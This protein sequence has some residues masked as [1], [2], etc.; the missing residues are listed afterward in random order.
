MRIAVENPKPNRMDG[1][2]PFFYLLVV[3]LAVAFGAY[4]FYALRML[5]EKETSVKMQMTF[6]LMLIAFPAITPAIIYLLYLDFF[7]RR[8]S[9]H[10]HSMVR[11]K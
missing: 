8:K 5:F 2:Y 9:M 10:Q 1:F 6:L 7:R 3:L 4:W 11:R